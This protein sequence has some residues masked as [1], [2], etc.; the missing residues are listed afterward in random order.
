[1][2]E[3]SVKLRS[4]NPSPPAGTDTGFAEK[5]NFEFMRFFIAETASISGLILFAV[6]ESLTPPGLRSTEAVLLT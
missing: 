4:K 2:E 3:K 6:D 1:L 5:G